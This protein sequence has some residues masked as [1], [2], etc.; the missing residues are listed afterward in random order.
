MLGNIVHPGRGKM[1]PRNVNNECLA[2]SEWPT[3]ILI[4][5]S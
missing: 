2:T 5:P 3:K 4:T 1:V